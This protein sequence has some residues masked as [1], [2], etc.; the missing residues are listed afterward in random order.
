MTEIVGRRLV[1]GLADL[2][3]RFGVPSLDTHLIEDWASATF[4]GHRHCIR[5]L[6]ESS[7]R[8]DTTML[9]MRLAE[10]EI[11]LPGHLLAD[12]ALAGHH[13]A[14]NGILLEIEALTLRYS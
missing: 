11:D 8:P 10:A 3:T 12:L 9:A 5:I 13:D 1:Q 7:R 4:V 14:A 6:L 2:L